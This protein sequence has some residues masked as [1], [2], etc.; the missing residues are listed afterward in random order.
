MCRYPVCQRL[1][2]DLLGLFGG[3]LIDAEP[4]DRHLDA[5]VQRDG[6]HGIASRAV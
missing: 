6:L 5:V 2:D 1:G 4:E 3:Y